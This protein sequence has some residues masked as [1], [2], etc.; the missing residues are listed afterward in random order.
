VLYA[1]VT[2]RNHSQTADI[3]SVAVGYLGAILF[4]VSVSLSGTALLLWEPRD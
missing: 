2:D 3:G 4:G 1:H